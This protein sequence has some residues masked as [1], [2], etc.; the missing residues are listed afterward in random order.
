MW[1]S[2]R[3]L[4][5]ARR[6]SAVAFAI[7]AALTLAAPSREARAQAPE[8]PSKVVRIVVPLTAGGGSDVL[9]RQLADALSRRLGQAV[10][11]DNK[12]GAG[13]NLG[14]DHV[15]KSA[16]DGYTLLLTPPA[17]I[18]QA[19]ALYKKLPYDPQRDLSFVSDIAQARVVCVVNPSVPARNFAEVV[20]YAKAN[21]DALTMG[22][23]GAGT[24]PHMVQA[25]M[26]L[27]F[28]TRTIHVPYKGEAPLVA[29]LVG[30]QVAMTCG[31]AVSL[32]PHL[33]AGR[34]RA[35]ATIG[36]ARA[37]VLPDVPTFAESGFPQ[38]VL[39]L[40]GPYTL[41]APAKTPPDVVERL[42]RELDAIVKSPQMREQIENLGM[43]PIG[44][45]P[46][47]A[48]ADYKA[49][50]PVILKAIRDTGATLD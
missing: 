44:N 7:G 34:L 5:A 16:A 24:Q 8:W 3:S 39:R 12:P 14:A 23:W 19:V 2:V 20:A 6:A 17:P 11:V 33:A 29:D 48:L 21:P 15:A 37:T 45:T 43:E 25:F 40:S 26:D 36:A 10:I 9:A 4:R 42:G 30:G 41:L 47:Q 50:L 32:K 28:G 46:A 22:S 1:N 18:T 35:I 49:R 31:S 38:D 13:G 27:Q